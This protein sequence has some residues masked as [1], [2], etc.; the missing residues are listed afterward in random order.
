V[1]DQTYGDFEAIL[2]NDASTD[3]SVQEMQRI[4]DSRI[5]ILE[6]RTPG[7]GGYA[8]RN[9]GITEAR[10][11]WI[12]FLDADDAWHREHLARTRD[13]MARFPDADVL[14]CGWITHVGASNST[15]DGYYNVNAVRGD[16]SFDI[17]SFICGARPIWTSVATVRRRR[18]LDVGGFDESWR[19]GGD[20]A[21]WLKLLLT[22]SV[23]A[24]YAGLG[25]TYFKDSVNMVTKSL[26]QTESPAAR[27]VQ[28]YLRDNPLSPL[29]M[30]L[31][32]Y[33]DRTMVKPTLRLMAR[34]GISRTD[35]DHRFYFAKR[36]S[37][38]MI[39]LSLLPRVVQRM[40]ARRLLSRLS[41]TSQD[42]HRWDL[43]EAR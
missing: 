25:A 8:A 37:R 5:R 28:Q 7:P 17:R 31:R 15:T 4:T 38:V 19:H 41:E 27:V 34:R 24:W 20:T 14:S 43:E 11:E 22:G 6:R 39:L 1:L 3:G 13:L 12:A 32:G 33:A 9:L 40:I 18:L 23:G 10:A 42:R 2:I 16:H 36:R 21:L 30:Q 29:E 35:L 26:T